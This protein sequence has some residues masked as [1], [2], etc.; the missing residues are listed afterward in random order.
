MKWPFRKKK[1]DEEDAKRNYTKDPLWY[2]KELFEAAQING[3]WC[4]ITDDNFEGVINNIEL[5]SFMENKGWMFKDMWVTF[6]PSNGHM[7]EYIFR[8]IK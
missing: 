5:L 8:K 3:N 2:A 1:E 6:I 7:A 4:V